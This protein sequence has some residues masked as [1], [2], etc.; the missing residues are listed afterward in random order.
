MYFKKGLHM[1][2]DSYVCLHCGFVLLKKTLL[3]LGGIL[4]T[5]ELTFN[6]QYVEKL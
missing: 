3:F 5:L 1:P 4:S 6:V 2:K